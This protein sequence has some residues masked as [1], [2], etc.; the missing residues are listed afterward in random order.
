MSA[1]TGELRECAQAFADKA[2]VLVR[3]EGGGYI[4]YVRADLVL[5]LTGRGTRAFLRELITDTKLKLLTRQCGA[6]R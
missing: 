5:P 3:Q 2:V 4:E 1:D 6:K